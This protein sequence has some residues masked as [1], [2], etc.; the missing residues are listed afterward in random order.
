MALNRSKV[1]F[2]SQKKLSYLILFKIVLTAMIAGACCEQSSVQ[3]R[4]FHASHTWSWFNQ[5]FF[6]KLS[7]HTCILHMQSSTAIITMRMFCIYQLS[8]YRQVSGLT[9]ASFNS[10]KITIK[11]AHTWTIVWLKHSSICCQHYLH[12]ARVFLN[13][14]LLISVRYKTSAKMNEFFLTGYWKK[15]VIFCADIY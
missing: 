3:H 5:H 2:T 6:I 4:L 7:I 13:K 14:C 12:S 15:T 11:Q 9:H 1:L 10:V 8:P